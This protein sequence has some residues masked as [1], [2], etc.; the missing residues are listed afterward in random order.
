LIKTQKKHNAVNN[1]SYIN[2][3][4]MKDEKEVVGNIVKAKA[5]YVTSDAEYQRRMEPSG[6]QQRYMVSL[7]T[8]ELLSIQQRRAR[9]R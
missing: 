6:T 5:K 1:Q 9:Q 3:N 8:S 2:D 4:T 7:L